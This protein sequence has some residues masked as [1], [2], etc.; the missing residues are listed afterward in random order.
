MRAGGQLVAAIENDP[1]ATATHAWRH[2]DLRR[3]ADARKVDPRDLPVF[4]VLTW[5]H[6]CNEH[7]WARGISPASASDIWM[8]LFLRVVRDTLPRYVLFEN[9]PGIRQAPGFRSWYRRLMSLGYWVRS[10]LVDSSP[11]VPQ[12]RERFFLLAARGVRQPFWLTPPARACTRTARSILDPK[13]G[14]WGPVADRTA[15][16]RRRVAAART[17]YGHSFLLSSFSGEDRYAG[18]ALNRP[19]GTITSVT[20]WQLVRGSEI[21]YLTPR[22][23][24]RAQ[25][26]DED[27]LFSGGVV[28]QHR[29]IGKACPP[30]LAR[31]A[32]EALVGA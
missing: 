1:H 17:R 26:F 30:P 3:Y 15:T 24:A 19:I 22:E 2:Q 20:H 16:V 28:A 31:A 21:R 7:S 8:R 5:C 27:Y 18:R 11:W 13:A 32:F 4:D 25:G 6:P 23:C 9:V 14:G 10:G 12:E 29:Q